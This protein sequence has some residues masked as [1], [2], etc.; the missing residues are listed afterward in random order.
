MGVAMM[1]ITRSAKTGGGMTMPGRGRRSS[2]LR[3]HLSRIDVRQLAKSASTDLQQWLRSRLS[4]YS[5]G[6]KQ[7]PRWAAPSA[8][9]A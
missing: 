8:I 3:P 9:S 4:P 7:T 2:R 5:S 1:R 6:I